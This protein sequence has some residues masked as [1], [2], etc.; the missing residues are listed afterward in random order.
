MKALQQIEPNLRKSILFSGAFHALLLG[1]FFFWKIYS[2]LEL[3]EFAEVQFLS[4]SASLAELKT[5]I[6][7]EAAPKEAGE[8][9]EALP[10]K[11]LTLPKRR[12]LE[13][14]EPKLPALPEEKLIPKE[15]APTL[16]EKREALPES[17]M[18]REQIPALITGEKKVAGITELGLEEK[19]MPEMTS[20]LTRKKAQPFKIE[21]EAANRTI[22]SKVIPQYPSGLQREARVKIEFTVLPNGLVGEMRPLLK[23]DAT[24]E[25]LTLE[26]FHQWRF[27]PLP[28]DV[29]QVAVK[30][31]ITFIYVLK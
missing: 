2:Q 3:P 7:A 8:K 9:I 4:V 26:A 19:A 31:V 6:L 16:V 15:E 5:E 1:L 24:L 12:M 29:P 23:G 21:G 28:A 30:G 22:L 10:P 17:T 18:I 25:K 11:L 14:E 13:E 20:E 27:N